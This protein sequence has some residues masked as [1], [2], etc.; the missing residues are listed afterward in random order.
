MSIHFAKESISA[1]PDSGY[2][3]PEKLALL[4]RIFDKACKNS[5][6]TD[7]SI[8]D[9]LASK[10]IGAGRIFDSE[11]VLIEVIKKAIAKL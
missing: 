5:C 4:K 1:R 6:V 10:L 8:R 9:N 11:D 2:Y 7:Q 3:S